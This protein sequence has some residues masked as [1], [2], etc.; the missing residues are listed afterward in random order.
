MKALLILVAALP[1]AWAGELLS[2]A[3]NDTNVMPDSYIIVMNEGLSDADFDSHMTWAM[4][5][6]NTAVEKRQEA[7]S[8]VSRT[9]NAHQMKGYCGSFDRETI[10]EIANNSDVAYVEP[11]RMMETSAFVTQ[12][13]APSYGLGRISHK[14]PG[15]RDYIFDRSAGRG[16]TIYGVDTGIDIQHPEFEGRITWGSNQVNNVDQ[17]ENGHGTHTAGT[18]AGTTFGVA[19]QA[20]I[21]AVKVLN[22]RGRGSASGIISGMNFCVNHAKQNNLLGRAVMNLSLGGGGTRAFNQAA[23]NA[24]NAGIFLA[25]AA[26]NDGV[27][28]DSWP[29]HKQKSLTL[30]QRDAANTSPASAR[31]VCTVAASTENDA[32][33]RFSN[34]GAVVAVYAPGDKITSA[35][36][37]GGSK[38]LSGTSMAAPHVAG[39]GAYLMA[40]EGITSDQVCNRIKSLAQPVISDQGAGTTNKLLYNN[41]GV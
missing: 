19:K 1:V 3:A 23:T 25:V 11:D 29:R 32:R 17:D 21:V 20:N 8:G 24:V 40:L 4:D 22:G 35:A 38:V 31:G 28:L 7:T 41:S 34:F 2:A 16:I 14:N 5:V 9:W 18:F 15:N 6:H 36:P 13:N 33:A 27:S 10:Q 12:R 39:V 37:G 30:L 26:G